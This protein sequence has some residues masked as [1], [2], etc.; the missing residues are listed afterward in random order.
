VSNAVRLSPYTLSPGD[1][2]TAIRRQK[3]VRHTSVNQFSDQ[4]GKLLFETSLAEHSNRNNGASS[5]EDRDERDCPDGIAE[6][7]RTDPHAHSHDEY[8]CGRNDG[9]KPVHGGP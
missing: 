2:H 7:C 8:D 4:P 9:S 6:Q 5:T 1:Q 3:W